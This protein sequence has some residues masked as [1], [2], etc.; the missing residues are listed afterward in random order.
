MKNPVI[1]LHIHVG[2][3]SMYKSAVWDLIQSFQQTGNGLEKAIDSEEKGINPEKLSSLLEA[4]G[5]D[6]GVC[7][8]EY[9]YITTG[10]ITN[11][12]V[13]SFCHGHPRLIPF[14]SINPYLV[15]RPE[16]ELKRCL[17]DLGMKGLKLYP[18]YQ[19]FYPD[20]RRLY[21][22]YQLAQ[23]RGIMVM[24]HTGSSIFPGSKIKF[25]DPIYWDE[26]A[27]DFPGL[28][29]ILVHS[30]RGFWYDKAA[31][32]AQLHAN[33]YLELAGL[34]PRNLLHYLPKLDK[35]SGKVIFGS[36][37]PAAPSIKQN[38]DEIRGLPLSEK[39]K[40]LILGGNAARLLGLD[41]T[42][43]LK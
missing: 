20:D 17:D 4:W 29:I 8:A 36:D 43:K 35:L 33:V 41:L 2:S 3:R 31:F 26:V 34:P 16:D 5:I 19:H 42:V 25:A 7:L 38:M 39:S 27:V 37:W 11:E 10:V 28:K 12:Y 40:M 14:A 13:A 21:P 18:S 23:E 22:M 15:T 6:Y 32:L 30:G 9:S 24:S 1:D